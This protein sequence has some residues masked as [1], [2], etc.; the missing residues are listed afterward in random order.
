[1]ENRQR[2]LKRLKLLRDTS[3]SKEHFKMYKVRKTWLFA[4]ITVLFFGTGIFF[5]HPSAYADT[6]TNESTIE[7]SSNSAS[8]SVASSESTSSAESSTTTS[9]TS[10]AASSTT[11]TS[12]TSATVTSS[13]AK[14]ISSAASS[15]TSSNVS[16]SVSASSSSETASSTSASAG[17]A[18]S[19]A[20]TTSSTSSNASSAT[21]SS[22]ASAVDSSVALSNS[23]SSSTSSG[24]EDEQQSSE[25]MTDSTATSE[26]SSSAAAV[27]SVADSSTTLVNPTSEELDQAKQ[28]A[29]TTYEETKVA[30]TLAAVDAAST[31]NGHTIPD[32]YTVVYNQDGIIMAVNGTISGTAVTG[33]TS[34]IAY[35]DDRSDVTALYIVSSMN[36]SNMPTKIYFQA[37][38]S[39]TTELNQY[40]GYDI[41]VKTA[42][43]SGGLSTFALGIKTT[44]SASY[45]DYSIED[46]AIVPSAE[47][48]S[49]TVSSNQ[50][51]TFTYTVNGGT[52]ETGTY[53][54]ALTDIKVGDAVVITPGNI[55]GYTYTQSNGTFT[56][57]SNPVANGDEV[58]YTAATA[59]A[60]I[61]VNYEDYF[62]NTIATSTQYTGTY[63]DAVK[64]LT[65]GALSVS[66]Y[67]LN[68]ADASN[69]PATAVTIGLDADGNGIATDANGTAVTSITLYYRTDVTL[70]ISGSKVYNGMDN[71]GGMDSAADDPN[72]LNNIVFTDQNGNVIPVDLASL[73]VV[74]TEDV[75]YY[76]SPNVGTYPDAIGFGA[77]RAKI[78]S[79]LT[80]YNAT[81]ANS[82]AG[83]LTITAAP[84]TATIS[85]PTSVTYD[86]SSHT[87]VP[88]VT[89]TRDDGTPSDTPLPDMP[90][91]TA[92]DF[93]YVSADRTVSSSVTDA[94]TY[95]VQ[96]SAAGLAKLAAA[97]DS[98]TD[99]T[100]VTPANANYTITPATGAFTITTAAATATL[101]ST[102][103]DYDGTTKA[104]EASGLT[105]TVNGETID[106]TSDDITV[107]DDGTNAGPY[108]Y[109]LSAAGI[110]AINSKLGG[111]AILSANGVTTGKITI[112]QVSGTVSLTGSSKVY[113]GMAISYVPT[114]T[115]PVSVTLTADDY[116]I[117]PT[118]NS[119]GSTDLKDAGDYT[120][121]LTQ[122]GIDKITSA[123]SNY[124]LNDLSKLNATYTINKKN[125]T[126][127]VTG[128]SKTY[129]GK[130][131]GAPT[132]SAPN[133]VTLTSEDY[134]VTSVSGTTY[135][136]GAG[137][138]KYALTQAG[139]DKITSTNSNYKLNDLSS[140][141]AEYTI[142]KREIE[143][144]TADDQTKVYGSD[145]P[146][147][148]VTIPKAAGNTGLISG[149]TLNY[150]VSRVAGESVGAYGINVTP[151]TNANYIITTTKAGILTIIRKL[152]KNVYLE[153]GSKVYDGK[154]VDYWPVVH[155]VFNDGTDIVLKWST[156]AANSDFVY[157][158]ETGSED[159]TGVGT[160][161]TTLST[162]GMD[163]LIA[164]NG[165]Y[166]LG[167]IGA[168]T[169]A[170]TYT[171]TAATASI[172]ING[173]N[174]V[175]DGQEIDYVPTISVVPTNTAITAPAAI[176]L[177]TGDYTIT[178]STG[179]K[180]V[181]TY[182]ITLTDQ[183]VAAIKAAFTNF[184]I[185]ID[186]SEMANY[187]I[188]AKPVTITVTGGTYE[189][190]GAA[191]NPTATVS[192]TANG[193]VLNYKL[194]GG[195]TYP[196]TKTVTATFD[197]NYEINKNYTISVI[198][199]TLTIIGDA[200]KVVTRDVTFTGGGKNTPQTVKQTFSYKVTTENG[201]TEYK[202]DTNSSYVVPII[203]GYTPS[204]NGQEL[205][206]N[207]D[208]TAYVL[209]Q[210]SGAP[211]GGTTVPT[212]SDIAVSYAANEESV[213]V[214]AVGNKTGTA[215][216]YTV[217]GGAS[218]TGTY[219][220]ALS[221]IHYDDVVVITPDTQTG[222]DISA[223]KTTVN[224][225]DDT[226]NNTVTVTYKANDQEVYVNFV[227]E[228]TG[229]VIGTATLKGKTD[230]TYTIANPPESF[231]VQF[232]QG[233]NDQGQLVNVMN[234]AAV[235]QL[236]SDKLPALEGTFQAGDGIP[237]ID[238]YDQMQSYTLDT[239]FYVR[240]AD[241]S[242]YTDVGPGTVTYDAEHNTTTY[243][244]PNGYDNPPVESVILYTD[245]D[246]FV[247]LGSAA[248]G[249]IDVDDVKLRVADD[250]QATATFPAAETFNPYFVV[251]AQNQKVTV[252]AVNNDTN[253]TTFS[254]TVNGGKA[255]VGT[256]GTELPDIVTGDV[257]KITPSNQAG[258][259]F[260]HATITADAD[261]TKDQEEMVTYSSVGLNQV[262][263]TYGDQPSYTLNLPEG[264]TSVSLTAADIDVTDAQT[265]LAAET[266]NDG[267]YLA[268][269]SYHISLNES[270]LDKL[271]KANLDY[272]MI[273]DSVKGATLVV[274]PKQITVT[275]DS[276]GKVYGDGDPELTGQIGA[277]I[278]GADIVGS[279]KLSYTIIRE[280][281]EDVGSYF[282]KVNVGNNTNY[283]V[284]PV[285][286]RFTITP[287]STGDTDTSVKVNDETSDYG[288]S[289]PEFTITPGKLVTDPG[290]LTNDD[291]TFI[292]LDTG[293]TI[294]GVPT[295]VGHYEVV[296]NTS[297]Q[298]KVEA[299]NP[300]YNFNSD[301]FISGTYTIN[302][303]ITHREIT[304]T[305]TVHYTGAGSKTPVDVVQTLNYDVATS[306]ATGNST[307][308]P[309]G[310]Y[311][312]VKTPSVTGYSNSGDISALTPTETTIKP[313]DTTVTV[314]YT[315]DETVT[316]DPTDPKDPTNP[317]DPTNPDGP[318][319]PDGVS[320]TDLNKTISRTITYTGANKNPASVTQTGSYTRTATVDAKTGEVLGYSDWVLVTSDDGN[321]N[322]DGFT[323]VISP[324]VTGYTADKNVADVTLDNDAVTNF[325]AG[326]DDETVTYTKDETVT[327]DP[328]DPKDPTNPIDPTNP[329]G[330]K[331]P[332]GV[333]E[334]DL[335]NT[336]SRTITYTGANKNP[337]S[338]AQT[339]TYTR[340]AFVDAKTGELLGYSDWTL[341]T[342]DDGNNNNDGF[343]G[344]TS[345]KVTGYKAD[346]NAPSV[347]LNDDE[348]AN[349]VAG[350]DDVLV[351]YT[352][353]NE[354]VYTEM[355]VTRT[356]HYVGAGS[357][358]PVDVIEKV[359]YKVGTNL[360]TGVVT[361]SPQNVYAKVETPNIVGYTNDGDVAELVPVETTIEPSNSLVVVHYKKVSDSGNSGNGNGGT[362]PEK[363]E[364]PGTP[365]PGESDGSGTGNSGSNGNSD[366]IENP[367]VGNHSDNSVD[368]TAAFGNHGNAQLTA[369][370]STNQ[371]AKREMTNKAS[372]LPQTDE[373][374]ENV[375]AVMGVTILS[376]MMALFGIKR[377]K[378]DD[379]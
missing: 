84:I 137:T 293:Q 276:Q 120:I 151:E 263:I 9:N 287:A 75:F 142:D 209:D 304:V 95:T 233:M 85:N 237:T 257:I 118:T 194:S 182:K 295:A 24:S 48:A 334:T 87:T 349:F 253:N 286:G 355:T 124:T 97:S 184:D 261:T 335:D 21:S 207:T 74:S 379:E 267:T 323:A 358:T 226:T 243:T 195:F 370:Q 148:T 56:A 176:T 309:E 4:G 231:N 222:Y 210:T 168:P 360:S 181:G 27:T 340:T 342:S 42:V 291:Y 109:T 89:Y 175:Y 219:G 64:N 268:A 45:F 110:E 46:G 99:G 364:N 331:Y 328:T 225:T 232:M 38:I 321:N 338:V 196:G 302:D 33:V 215:F 298:A 265:G 8:S 310:S 13:V 37:T 350:S 153:D 127:T 52:P 117:T 248:A 78:I 152:T 171:I 50:T 313:E 259:V 22:T 352:P 29:L 363:P 234:N 88:T 373:K 224:V 125:A 134:T 368:N 354:I 249:V 59:T 251:T 93:E 170:G 278:I 189:Y 314:T 34:A 104:S 343:A 324:K 36:G 91:W 158:P 94:G 10:S 26:I 98:T 41:P 166:Y 32:G 361:Y 245:D 6:V 162:A 140:L 61:N 296:L 193:E 332:D 254:Y 131:V 288:D 73:N 320:E 212:I 20:T 116:T 372:T 101:N 374:N 165:N 15:A 172:T 300:N 114:V 192:E 147:L 169:P 113:D 146:T 167:G 376:A 250:N 156:K 200:Y 218:Q 322:N 1:M 366:N 283:V 252:N 369:N 119:T 90:S 60:T 135:L 316:V 57:A 236:V 281:G 319:Y 367:E 86:G 213:T 289:T 161:E 339:A 63:G 155:A 255:L 103:F 112:N 143:I 132:I 244:V 330:P 183:G 173:S 17:S 178:G 242:T 292:N 241:G 247:P 272:T 154:A 31:V 359:I 62:G 235:L 128:G 357:K 65:T 53:G 337:A 160:Y 190:D 362:K 345:P 311:S 55:K 121:V 19:S 199:G 66:G 115:A 71:D 72:D 306:K 7:A 327:V 375:V 102:S 220:T 258:F 76:D 273:L 122:A 144:I 44:G 317:I 70:T 353:T 12:S 133:G 58:T 111:N 227:E 290:N 47:T 25:S 282:E 202:L 185:T 107:T 49:V 11:A 82:G 308:T 326:S 30:Q 260:K 214:T 336:I 333:S 217:N 377:R 69:K 318:K 378:H 191:H 164:A 280:A 39:S 67:K 14:S 77:A 96:F 105:A 150:T 139:I 284:V 230:G 186:D 297:G 130:V 179:L 126:V 301:D 198:T 262:E 275:A 347:T 141:T 371:N 108:S 228:N 83:D 256:Y 269:G 294:G 81:I 23:D 211:T 221:G 16:S 138:Y 3:Q 18:T 274:D 238:I 28:I 177:K 312:A 279:D 208:K 239:E 229:K 346:K 206:F 174:K 54:N 123:N 157:T 270:G 348:V 305:R 204:I 159:L 43:P 145:D 163:N 325:V 264:L 356:I 285:A 271:K 329:D 203:T 223:D 187:M 341:V 315:K 216:T 5:G 266:T 344:V 197:P 240:S 92:D 201:T 40:G 136:T 299:A 246:V 129:D 68:V 2:K 188:T 100:G 303:V 307:Y 35:L 80:K 149:D 277:D 106:L 365:S 205:G 180:D 51:G 79:S 351:T